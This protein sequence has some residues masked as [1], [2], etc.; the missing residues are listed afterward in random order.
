MLPRIED[1]RRFIHRARAGLTGPSP[2]GHMLALHIDGRGGTSH[3]VVAL[4]WPTPAVALSDRPHS[5]IL[6][7]EGSLFDTSGWGVFGLR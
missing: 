1:G 7:G 5:L 2:D 3:M 6:C 4:L